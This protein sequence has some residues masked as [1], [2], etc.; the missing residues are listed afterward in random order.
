LLKSVL[1]RDYQGGF[2]CSCCTPTV[3][4]RNQPVDT[5]W[6]EKPALNWRKSLFKKN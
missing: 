1:S 5:L 6:K 4:D 2:V 3:L